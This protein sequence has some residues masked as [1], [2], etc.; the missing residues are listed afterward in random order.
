[1]LTGFDRGHALRIRRAGGLVAVWLCAAGLAA[2]SALEDPPI[3]GIPGQKAGLPPTAAISVAENGAG[4]RIAGGGLEVAVGVDPFSFA[5]TRQEDGATLLESAPGPAPAGFGAL[6]FTCDRGGTWNRAFWGYR[7]YLGVLDPWQSAGRVERFDAKPDRV[8]LDVTAGEGGPALF[9]VGP[10][11]DGA[12]RLAAAVTP[13]ET[14]RARVAFT[15]AA[16]DGEVYAGFG[17]RFNGVDQRGNRL[18]NWA[19]EG[20]I[21]PGGLRAAFPRWPAEHAIPGGQDSTY[22]PIPFFI[23]N[24][25]YGLLADVPEPTRFDLA[26]TVPDR[27]RVQAEAHRLSVVVFSG[28]EP[29]A[30]LRRYTER[31]GRSQVP[32]PWV[33]GPWNMF[34]G[35]KQGAAL[36][37][38]GLFRE[39]DIPSSV[40]FDWTAILP[41]SSYRGREAALRRANAAYHDLGYKSLCYIQPRVDKGRNQALWDEGAA[42]GHFVRDPA[43]GPYLLPVFLNL[44]HMS[45][46]EVSLVDFTH[47]GVDAWWHERLRTLIDL[48]FDGTMY[49]FGEY[50]PPDAQFSDGHDGHYWHNAYNLIYLR[51]AYRFFEGLDDDPAD[52]LAPD[53]VYFHRSGYAGS[54][55]WAW[56]M[57]DGDPS[58]SWA[59]SDGLPAQVSAGINAGLSGMPF[60][61][62]DIGGYHAYLVPAP[63]AELLIR[64]IEFGA[65]SGLMRDMNA[66]EILLGKR[67]RL[68]DTDEVAAVTRRYQ[69]LRTQ[70]VPYIMNAAREAHATGLPLMRAAC[71]HFPE[72]P[73]CWRLEREYLFGPDFF[74]APVVEEGARERRV[75]LPPGQWIA[76]WDRT[77]YDGDGP[78]STGG[79]RIGG[80]PIQGGREIVV[81]APLEQIP[82][83]VRL[84]AVIPVADPR[85][86]TW[87]PAHP[88]EGTAVTAAPDLAHLLHVWAFPD[89]AGGTTLSDGSRLEVVCDPEGIT[90]T[91]SPT[92]PVPGEGDGGE[93][94]P[95]EV[96]AQVA[97]PAGLPAPAG[98]EGLTRVEDTDPF[99]LP[100]GSWCWDPA[101]NALALHGRPGETQFRLAAGQ[102]G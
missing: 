34:G 38:A 13:P 22:A 81:D 25:G 78:G 55:H 54:Q 101:R 28:P 79:F 3:P 75:Y 9:V 17:E 7:G 11:Y 84:G 100:P 26:D 77:E 96:V 42:L 102:P 57:W 61:G 43:G 37:V 23:S 39:R 36:E 49:D 32:R 48:G 12:V 40:A 21:E 50:T 29:A 88:P 56:A 52:G 68:L 16:P 92:A 35:Y 97:W 86:D 87:A 8:V 27:W 10:F 30:I 45:T 70:L 85:V 66:P 74:V 14:G 47:E 19:E 69:K 33:F 15:F 67:I 94:R 76:F 90:L 24:R 18:V 65:F 44:L 99:A 83:F 71:L 60:W 6:A 51:S 95:A 82:V 1:M 63:T 62:S 20:S 41:T 31:T 72:D 2:A 64:W 53:Y 98:V 46:Y 59:A 5:I 58:A 89:G 93:P 4:L 73:P 91:R 80:A